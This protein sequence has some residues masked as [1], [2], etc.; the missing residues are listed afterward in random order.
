MRDLLLFI[1]LNFNKF[2]TIFYN[3]LITFIILLFLRIIIFN[4]KYFLQQVGA[5]DY[6]SFHSS[7]RNNFTDMASEK[8]RCK[9]KF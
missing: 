8:S 7:E 6:N 9:E 3:L 5:K 1:K 4:K 2:F